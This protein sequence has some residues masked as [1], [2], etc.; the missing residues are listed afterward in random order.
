MAEPPL[1]RIDSLKSLL[2][3]DPK[4]ALI[5]YMLANE[6]LKAKQYEEALGELGVYFGIADDE[7][8][9][10]RMAA[11]AH[12]SLGREEEAKQ[13]YRKGIEA[14][15]RHNHASMV[16]EFEGALEDLA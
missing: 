11:A 3:Q 5:H 6:Y 1:S 16:S 12:L 10:Y 7:G 13:A 2:D 4:N 9:G 8:S 15:R 14:A